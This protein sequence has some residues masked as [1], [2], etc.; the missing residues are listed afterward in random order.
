MYALLCLL[1]FTVP[2]E[3]TEPRILS[4]LPL[5]ATHESH[6]MTRDYGVEQLL[7]C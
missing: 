5:F 7:V 2:E 4:S 6:N 1:L 3:G